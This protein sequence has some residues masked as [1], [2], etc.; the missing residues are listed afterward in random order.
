MNHSFLGLYAII[1]CHPLQPASKRVKLGFRFEGLGLSVSG[2]ES[3]RSWA[4]FQRG[5]LH[6][7]IPRMA[8]G[9][10]GLGFEVQGIGTPCLGVPMMRM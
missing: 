8:S 7:P 2:L 4:T 9:F 6:L 1:L 10:R 5:S 3:L